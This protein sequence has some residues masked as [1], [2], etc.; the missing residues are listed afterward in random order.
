MPYQTGQVGEPNQ[1]LYYKWA[2]NV[3]MRYAS[4]GGGLPR[5]TVGQPQNVYLSLIVRYLEA[6]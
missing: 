2:Y 5:P 6:A 3:W 4:N 1:T